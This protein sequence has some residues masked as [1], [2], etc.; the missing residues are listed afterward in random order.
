MFTECFLVSALSKAR[1]R[2]AICAAFFAEG[3]LSTRQTAIC[4]H[5]LCRVS[6]AMDVTR[7][8]SC[9]Q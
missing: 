5:D 7:Q 9:I 1:R 3:Q 8:S 2:L 6:Y 4:R